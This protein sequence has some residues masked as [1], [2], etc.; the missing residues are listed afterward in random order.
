MTHLLT[1][2]INTLYYIRYNCV[3]SLLAVEK[4]LAILS[5]QVFIIIP[6][7]SMSSIDYRKSSNISRDFPSKIASFIWKT[8]FPSLRFWRGKIPFPFTT[9]DRVD[10]FVS[11]YQ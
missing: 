2:M 9:R 3:D 4:L 8:F 5:I 6:F 1:N 7:G 11:R 10:L